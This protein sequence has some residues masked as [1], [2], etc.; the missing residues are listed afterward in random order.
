M[1]RML[2]V[3]NEP[4]GSSPNFQIGAPRVSKLSPQTHCK[5]VFNRRRINAVLVMYAWLDE[6]WAPSRV[7]SQVKGRGRASLKV[8]NEAEG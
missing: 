1:L 6:T 4:Q 2:Q 8:N 5:T 3:P 7:R